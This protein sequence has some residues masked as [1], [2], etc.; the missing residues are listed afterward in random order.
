MREPGF[1]QFCL[2]SCRI[3]GETVERSMRSSTYQ[4]LLAPNMFR[5][6]FIM[7]FERVLSLYLWFDFT[8]TCV[9]RSLKYY[10]L[11]D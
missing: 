7:I 3:S 10:S 4:L 2:F 9:S 1:S 5:S 8:D 6:I 11:L